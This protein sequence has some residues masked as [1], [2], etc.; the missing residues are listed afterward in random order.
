M[1]FTWDLDKIEVNLAEVLV[2]TLIF[3]GVWF[4]LEYATGQLKIEAK[5]NGIFGDTFDAIDELGAF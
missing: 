1:K 3:A 4:G 2:S 5:R